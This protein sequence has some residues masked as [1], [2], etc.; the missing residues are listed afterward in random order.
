MA[1]TAKR[2]A[3][4]PLR[5]GLRV[6]GASEPTVF[7]IYGA[8]GDLSQRKLLPAI[9]NLAV[10]GLLP[11]RF[12]VIG[13]SRS[14]MDNDAFRE[15]ARTAVEKFSRTPVD[16]HLWQGVR[17]EPP[18][19]VGQLRRGGVQASSASASRRSTPPTGPAGTGSTTSRRPRASSR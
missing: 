12:A 4:N 18:L 3:P 1:T 16:D 17:R 11:N 10:R 14:E 8:S 13:Y 7:V 19:P 5:A 6:G 9:Y 15:F 2:P